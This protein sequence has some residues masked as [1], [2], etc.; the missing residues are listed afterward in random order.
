[1]NLSARVIGSF[2][3]SLLVFAA[4]ASIAAICLIALLPILAR[5]ALARPNDR[6]SHRQ[7]TPQGGGIAVI[8]A[9]IIVIACAILFYPNIFDTPR[10]LAIV[11]A[12]AAG[13]AIVGATDDIRP[14]GVL[15]RLILQGAAVAVTIAMLPTE[16]RVVAALPWWLERLT[17]LVGG[18]WFVNL[19]NFMDGIDWMMVAEV[20]PMTAALALFGMMGALPDDA[21]L[22]AIALCGATVGFAPFNRP[23]A[24]MFLGDVGSLPIG[25]L[26]GWLLVSLAGS[27]H[28]AASIM[29]PLYFLADATITVFRRLYNREQIAQAHRGHFYQRAVDGGFSVYQIVGRVFGLNIVLASLATL[30]VMNTS[31]ALQVIVLAVGIVL[32]GLLLWNFSRTD[33]PPSGGPG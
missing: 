3:T 19:V 25:L 33:R 5:H 7:P 8:A 28:L 16:L 14:Q 4:A 23:I 6:S 1:M 12:A 17:L 32:V 20:V 2:E 26:L 9:V 27:G 22:V 18:V 10:H 11:L 13:L 24:R 30:T 31:A 29:L 15:P 21:M